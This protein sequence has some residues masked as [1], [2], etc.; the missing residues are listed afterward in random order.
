MTCDVSPVAMFADKI[1]I[2]IRYW[3]MLSGSDEMVLLFDND[4]FMYVDFLKWELQNMSN[5][6]D[7][8]KSLNQMFPWEKRNNI[9]L[10]KTN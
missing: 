10:N 1:V 7:E 4:D 6:L 9:R 8:A 3:S 2:I 5:L